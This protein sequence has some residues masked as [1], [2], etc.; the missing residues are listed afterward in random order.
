MKLSHLLLTSSLC[1]VVSAPAIAESRSFSAVD[2]DGNGNL[3]LGELIEVFG[4]STAEDIIARADRDED[5][6]L[7]RAEVRASFS[8]DDEEDDDEEDGDDSESD[9]AE[10]TED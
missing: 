10:D 9:D 3:T 5:G 2:T 6:E 7:T 1:A 4:E 8:N